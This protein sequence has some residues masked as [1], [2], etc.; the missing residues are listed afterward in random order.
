MNEE[1]TWQQGNACYLAAALNWVRLRLEA[2]AQRNFPQP[3]AVDEPLTAP[4]ESEPS[5]FSR[6][7]GPGVAAKYA[8]PSGPPVRLLPP[9][10]IAANDEQILQAA[11][12]ME[13][14]AMMEPPPALLILAERFGL[15]RFERDVL[16]LCCGDGTRHQHRI[17]L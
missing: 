2:Q 10:M 7:F 8:R 15:S 16:L 14:A 4:V 1:T 3:R 6:W 11:K 17:A 9:A 12:A 5:L 13:S